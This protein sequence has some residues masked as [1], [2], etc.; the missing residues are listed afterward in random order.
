MR[1][2]ASWYQRLT[3]KIFGVAVWDSSFALLR[4]G[5]IYTYFIFLVWNQRI[6]VADFVL[7]FGAVAGFS[8]WLSNLFSQISLLN[9]LNLKINYFRSYLEYPENFR[10]NQ[11]RLFQ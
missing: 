6:S 3:R 5:I 2:I 10:R 1:G 7:Y 4:E 8:T 9:Q 11:E